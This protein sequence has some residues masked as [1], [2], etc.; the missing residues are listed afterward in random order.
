M[1]ASVMDGRYL[2]DMHGPYCDMYNYMVSNQPTV[3]PP[4][5]YVV[6]YVQI[7]TKCGD[8]IC[9]IE[10]PVSWQHTIGNSSP[11]ETFC[12]LKLWLVLN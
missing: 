8:I 4:W 2:H 12:V 11:E 5:L 9:D 10:K 6:P 1:C 7:V 3:I